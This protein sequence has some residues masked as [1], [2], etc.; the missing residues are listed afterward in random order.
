MHHFRALRQ[1]WR[2]S[3]TLLSMAGLSRVSKVPRP[4]SY[5]DGSLELPPLALSV[6]NRFAE[7]ESPS[8]RHFFRALSIHL[9]GAHDDPCLPL[10]FNFALSA[11]ERGRK[12]VGIIEPIV[13]LEGKRALDVGCAYGGFLVALAERGAEPMGFDIDPL[14][15]ALGEHNFRDAGRRFP[16]YLAD[17]TKAD[18]VRRFIASFDVITCND[19]IEHVTDPAI[20]ISH[21]AAMLRP[22]GLAYFE[23]PNKDEVNF[24]LADGHYQL[25]GITQLDRD[26]AYRYYEA[27]AP[28]IRYGVEHYLQLYEY[29][30]LF[31]RSGLSMELRVDPTLIRSVEAIDAS[32][33]KLRSA[34][35]AELGAVPAII[36]GDVERAVGDYLSKAE[37]ARIA[38]PEDQQAYRLRYGT[39]FW[40]VIA[41]KAA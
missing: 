41:R 17:I 38:S 3:P 10:Y 5:A 2:R 8:N 26:R 24:V 25:F 21:V 4:D 22:G 7:L 39:A 40:R 14:L 32:L 20:A 36:R 31:E 37:A 1:R 15:L 16:T 28:G 11:N 6:A 33:A 12:A 30:E 35:Q 18:D 27:H 19:V 23:I 9:A 34:L 13:P 29:R